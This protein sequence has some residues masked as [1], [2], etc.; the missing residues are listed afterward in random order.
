MLI[1]CHLHLPGVNKERSFEEAKQRLLRD[2]TVNDV[3][4][5]ILIPDNI[6]GS[7][8]GDLDTTLELTKNESRLFLMGTIDIFKDKQSHLEKLDFLFKQKYI[9]GIKIFPGHEPM[10]PTDERLIPVY[11]LC[12]KHDLPIIIHTGWNPGHPEVAKY[13]DPKHIIKIAQTFPQLNIVIAHYFW[14]KVEYCHELTKTFDNIYFDISGL[15]DDEVIKETGLEKIKMVLVETVNEHPDHVVFGT[16]YPM[17][18][19]TEHIEL[20]N[21]LEI[22]EENKNKIFYRNALKLFKLK[23]VN[24]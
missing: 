10:Y 14:P 12:V 13:N 7:T 9:V 6:P 18:S 5:A 11:N 21:S 20:V 23:I 4:Y 1:D 17:C 2:L 19:L 22:S 3:D 24:T 8:I 16:D 15:A